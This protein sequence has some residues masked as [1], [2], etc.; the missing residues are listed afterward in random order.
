MPHRQQINRQL[1]VYGTRC[2]AC[3]AT[4]LL[5]ACQTLP[6]DVSP[7]ELQS[8]KPLPPEHRIMQEVKMRW[9]VRDDVAQYCARAIQ[10]GQEQ[11]FI[12]PP[13]ACA[14][15]DKST[16][17]CTIVTGPKVSHMVLGHEVRH[18]FE[19]HFHR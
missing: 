5:A 10:M 13:L 19:G 9:L 8:F 6:Q 11:A 16:K 14:V 15:W 17:E 3:M 18:C 4:L 12:T 2:L 7:Q 1:R